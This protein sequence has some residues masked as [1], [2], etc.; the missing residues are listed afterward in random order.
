MVPWILIAIATTAT[1]A[2]SR[3]SSELRREMGAEVRLHEQQAA[4]KEATLRRLEEEMRS[5]DEGISL[6]DKALAALAAALKHTSSE[7]VTTTPDAPRG[8]VIKF[9]SGED[10]P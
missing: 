5:I 6:A 2:V 8:R 4:A 10:T 3:R 1:V 9:P 7:C